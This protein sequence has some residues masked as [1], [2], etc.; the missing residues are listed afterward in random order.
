MN[1]PIAVT[2]PVAAPAPAAPAF[3]YFKK[4]MIRVPFHVE[5]KR[6]EFEPLDKNYGVLKLPET[7][8]LVPVLTQAASL[9]RGGIGVI[10]EAT[11][12]E[13]KKKLPF[14]WPALKSRPSTLRVAPVSVSKLR[15]RVTSL[16]GNRVGGAAGADSIF[17]RN[18]KISD[19][20]VVDPVGGGGT[21]AGTGIPKPVSASAPPTAAD[22][23]PAVGKKHLRPV[24]RK[25]TGNSLNPVPLEPGAEADM[26]RARG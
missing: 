2:E 8:P 1:D 21:G 4:T 12:A 15:Q 26:V 6:V 14:K 24:L 16:P 20:A 13:L 3:A 7:S 19:G 5:Q 25:A 9:R 10:D 17:V 18:R 11:Y 22:F 23:K